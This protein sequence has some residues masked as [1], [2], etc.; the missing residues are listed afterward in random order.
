[1]NVMIMGM[2]GYLGWTLSMYLADKGHKVSGID[3]MLRRKMVTEIGSQSAVGKPM[4]WAVKPGGPTPMTRTSAP[5][6]RSD[7]PTMSGSAAYA[8]CQ[9][10]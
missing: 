10:R 3:N 7:V 6:T 2:D 9:L 5:F 1:M 4:K 8:C